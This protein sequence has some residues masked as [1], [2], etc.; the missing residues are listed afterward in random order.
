MKI[1]DCQCLFTTTISMTRIPSPEDTP[2][3]MTAASIMEMVRAYESDG[4]IFLRSGDPVN[5]LAGFYY[6]FGWLHYGLSSGLLAMT[7][8]PA[9][10][11][12][13]PSEKLPPLFR[14]KLEEKSHRYGRLLDTAMSSVVCAPDPAT[15]NHNY[16]M[17]VLF[18]AGVY[19]GQGELF[20]KSG[21]Y[22]EALACFSYGHG[23]ID[24][25]VTA[26]LYRI[27]SNRDIFCV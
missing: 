16:A 1:T 12:R 21:A 25:G 10:P 4:I 13:D 20:L 17:R 14:S 19:A 26:G 8:V 24:A 22:E 5:A 15:I 23:W 18:V 2:L 7:G 9:C 11:F 6:G 3:N 27:T